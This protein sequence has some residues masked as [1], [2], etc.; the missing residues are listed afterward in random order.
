MNSNSSAGVLQ[1]GWSA[2][3]S[4]RFLRTHISRALGT[5]RSTIQWLCV[6][7]RGAL[8]LDRGASVLLAVILLSPEVVPAAA[9]AQ[10]QGN[11]SRRP[12]VLVIQPDQHRGTIL[13][14][15]GDPQARTP[16]LDRLAR[17]GILFRHSVSS[18]PVCCPF[19]ATM[20]TGLYPHR[21]G[22]LAND[23]YRLNPKDPTFAEV[24]AHA[25]Y[26]T[27]YI[28]K[29]HLDGGQPEKEGGPGVTA[30][31][32]GGFVP[33][34]RRRGYQE[35]NGYEKAHE[36]FEVWKYNQQGRKERVTG[37]DWEPT[38]HTDMAL[39]FA[40]RHTAEGE[41]WLYYIAFGPPH[42]PEQCPRRFL[43]QFPLDKIVLPPDVRANFTG[44]AETKIREKFQNYYA[45]VAAI[46]F[47]IG[48][49]LDGLKRLGADENTI[50][51]YTS[52]H[53]D[54]LG[55][56]VASADAE[57]LRGKGS[58]YATAF[59]TPLIIRWPARIK[60]G[61]TCDAL[62]SSVDLAPTLLDLA[63]A[64]PIPGAQ[65]LSMAPWCLAGEGPRREAVW[66]G[67]GKWRA[68]WDGRFV[69]SPEP[70]NIL[71]DH[72][73]DPHEMN[74]LFTAPESQGQKKRLHEL[75]VK[76]AQEVQDPMAAELR[77]KGM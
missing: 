40:R 45:L 52:D 60:P 66:I 34:E 5:T 31:G 19:R 65:G 49:L 46:D 51:L 26:K 54:H 12:N 28:G 72:R 67:L 30:K 61:S 36:Y 24:F 57:K 11:N 44:A 42:V 27:G 10:G 69:Y 20:Q 35:W 1:S 41:P 6:G 32:V 48:R 22:V 73:S 7:R 18:S 64:P 75:L 50:I 56:H 17:E 9:P 77:R 15:M 23:K 68:A 70:Y 38:W 53:G 43:D 63:G 3:T 14:C 8:P 71:Y 2:W 21:H 33:P 59:R 62:V 25:G 58:P 29:W 37:Y 74:N 47:E 55:S 16:N 13:G 4:T 76:V 39:D